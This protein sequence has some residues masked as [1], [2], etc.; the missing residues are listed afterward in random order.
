MPL[1]LADIVL[2]QSPKNLQF[3][4]QLDKS[5]CIQFNRKKEVESAKLNKIFIAGLFSLLNINNLNGN[6]S[7]AALSRTTVLFG[8]TNCHNQLLICIN[9]V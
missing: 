4:L 6:I 7:V 9:L 3:L 5:S 2:K 1:S 8:H